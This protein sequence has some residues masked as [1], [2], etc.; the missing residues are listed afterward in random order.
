MSPGT[1]LDAFV[2]RRALRRAARPGRLALRVALAALSLILPL[3][4]AALADPVWVDGV[5]DGGDHDLL[6]AAVSDL[7]P[8]DP[9]PTVLSAPSLVGSLPLPTVVTAGFDP[10]GTVRLRAPPRA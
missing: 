7:S 2:R 1:F 9:P 6:L 3:A 5:Y 10:P 4:G 8:L